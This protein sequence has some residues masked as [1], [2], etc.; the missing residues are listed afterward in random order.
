MERG[1][2][3]HGPRVDEE[4]NREVSGAVQGTAGA[5]AEEWRQAEPPGEDQPEP[6]TAPV[7]YDRSGTP[8][9]MTPDEVEQ[10]SRLGRYIT[11]TALPG[12]R[13][14]L[15]RS[16]EESEAPADILDQLDRLPSDTEF[17]TVSEVWA[18]LGH[19]NETRR[20]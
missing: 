10:R 20:W 12:D 5:R 17:Q 3:K 1:N 4:M 13:A 16:A 8:Q 6:T 14:T 15:R 7:A 2:S 19:H 11:L 9:G 18:A